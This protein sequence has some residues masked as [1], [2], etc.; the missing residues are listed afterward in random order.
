M[1]VVAQL[2]RQW[3]GVGTV[4]LWSRNI[5]INIQI[6]IHVCMCVYIYI[7]LSLSIYKDINETS[8]KCDFLACAKPGT[9]MP[10]PTLAK[11]SSLKS[12][13]CKSI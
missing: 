1:I 8:H 4:D 13:S 2:C 3:Q 5:Y 10:F 9:H 7:Y 12:G 11:V 6:H